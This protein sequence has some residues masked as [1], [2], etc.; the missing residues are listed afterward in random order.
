MSPCTVAHSHALLE[1]HMSALESKME[2]TKKEPGNGHAC[3]EAKNNKGKFVCFVGNLRRD[4]TE[5]ELRTLFTNRGVHPLSIRIIIS[6]KHKHR[7]YSYVDFRCREDKEKVLTWKGDDS[8]TESGRMV[9]IDWATPQSSEQF[10]KY[11]YRGRNNNKNRNKK[12]TP[13]KQNE[14]PVFSQQQNQMQDMGSVSQG[15]KRQIS[16]EYTGCRWS[17]AGDLGEILRPSHTVDLRNFEVMNSSYQV[18]RDQERS[19]SRSSSSPSLII[20]CSGS[21]IDAGQVSYVPRLGADYIPMDRASQS[22]GVYLSPGAGPRAGNVRQHHP[23]NVQEQHE[24]IFP[25][26]HEQY[27]PNMYGQYPPTSPISRHVSRTP[28]SRSPSEGQFNLA[29]LEALKRECERKNAVLDAALRS[30][31]MSLNCRDLTM[32]CS[33]GENMFMDFGNG[34]AIG[35]VPMNLRAMLNNQRLVDQ[36]NDRVRDEYVAK[37]MAERVKILQMLSQRQ[38]GNHFRGLRMQK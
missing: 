19:S 20:D 30:R 38:M 12:R 7:S 5:K 8:L 13:M 3:D 36:E 26:F 35:N 22:S 21:H 33:N 16:P 14:N 25:H 24:P 6:A 34:N 9:N 29:N 31:S 17:G 37:L 27:P 28:P 15:Q 18:R 32:K 1:E 4:I 2:M 11:K 23:L 10:K